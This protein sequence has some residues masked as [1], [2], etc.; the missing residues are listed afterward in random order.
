MKKVILTLCV[1]ILAVGGVWF[2]YSAYRAS[3]KLVTLNVRDMPVRDVCKLIERQTWETI[4]VANPVEGKVTL[5]VKNM[6]LEEVLSI[7]SEQVNARYSAVY[8]LYSTK[9]SL[10]RLIQIVL[11]N[12]KEVSGWKAWQVRPLRGGGMFA[13]TLRENNKL[14]TLQ[15]LDKD[16]E[17]AALALSRFG[18][19]Q[20][21]PEDSATNRVKLFMHNA[22]MEEAVAR[23]AKQANRKW[24]VFYTLQ[25]GF[26]GRFGGR[27]NEGTNAFVSVSGADTNAPQFG[28]FRRMLQNTNDATDSTNVPPFSMGGGM[29]MDNPE[30]QKRL[31][32]QL[33]TMTPEERKR[34][35]EMRQQMQ[36]LRNLPPEQRAERMRELFS[37][38]EM[39]Q[40]MQSRMVNMIKNTTP[41]QR[42]ERARRILEM[43]QRFENRPP[44]NQ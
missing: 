16:V 12:E 40:R 42:V 35:E 3:K 23:L 31:E 27:G 36:E 1:A 15:L 8:P 39:Q 38:P 28:F 24:T 41:E 18:R 26:F 20:I 32:A 29:G 10:E 33:A 2:G 19:V 6:P 14:I 25:P 4:Y 34:F 13:E 17:F 21:V 7:V 5:R 11:G 9:S 30:A 37:S 44:P 43:R 22:T